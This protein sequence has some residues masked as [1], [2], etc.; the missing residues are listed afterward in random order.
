MIIPIGVDCEMTELCKKYNLRNCSLPFDWAVTYNGVS[1]CI[2]EDFTQFIPQK[3]ERINAYDV[4]FHHDFESIDTY[5]KDKEKYDRRVQRIIQI[6]QTST[7]EVVFCRKGHCCY[8]HNEQ[9]GRYTNIKN[10]IEDAEEL[11]TVLSKKYPELHYK[12]NVILICGKCFDKNTQYTSTSSN[13]I[14]IYNIASEKVE[15]SEIDNCFRSIFK[16]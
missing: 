11:H 15:S 5:D 1:K 6:L 4:Y 2:E 14:E 9:N 12:I 3:N 7:E 13:H 8:H 16:I 10:E